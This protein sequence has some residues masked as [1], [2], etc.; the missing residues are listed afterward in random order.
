MARD[1]VVVLSVTTESELVENVTVATPGNSV[2]YAGGNAATVDVD[3]G[4]LTAFRFTEVDRSSDRYL[5]TGAADPAYV[6]VKE[7]ERAL[8][9]VL[10]DGGLSELTTPFKPGMY[11]YN[12]DTGKYHKIELHGG[13]EADDEVN[14]GVEQEGVQK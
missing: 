5:V 3:V 9:A 4:T 14:I 12:E 13:T 10:A 8:D 11:F 1:F 7:I 6:A 2:D